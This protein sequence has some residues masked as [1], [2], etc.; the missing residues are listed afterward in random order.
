MSSAVAK[1]R[2]TAEDYLAWEEQQTEK[3][4]FIDGQ[5]YAMAGAED[6]HVTVAGNVFF[7]LRQHLAGTP[8]RT[9]ISDMRVQVEAAGNYYYPDVVVTCAESDRGRRLDKTAPTLLVEVLSPSTAAHDR[10]RKFAAYRRIP[11]LREYMLVDPDS[12]TT[13]VYRVGDDGLWVLHPYARDDVVRLASV[14]LELAPAQLW[15]DVVDDEAA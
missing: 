1:P 6:R 13:D 7:A 5:V 14:G 15:A 2:L 3:H 8:C 4:E 12:R 9:Y 11:Q 10:G